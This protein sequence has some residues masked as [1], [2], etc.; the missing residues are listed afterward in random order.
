MDA[1]ESFL[2]MA[3]EKDWEFSSLRRA[4]YSTMA[5]VYNLH[6]DSMELYTCNM[7]KNVFLNVFHCLSCEVSNIFI[8]IIKII[9]LL[10]MCLMAKLKPDSGYYI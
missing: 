3:R 6:K 5:L 4:R 1:R 7:C 8:F 10:F 9:S 2:N